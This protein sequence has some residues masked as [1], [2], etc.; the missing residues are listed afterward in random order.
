MARGLFNYF[1]LNYSFIHKLYQLVSI[2]LP[3]YNR[4]KLLPESIQS[5]LDQS[6]TDFE[7]I[8]T[9]DGSDDG[10][11]ELVMSIKD[12]RI[13]YFQFPH[14]GCTSRLKNFAIRQ[15]SGDFFAF[16]DSD[17]MWKPGKLEKQMNLFADNPTIGFSITDATT[18]R[19]DEILID[20]T[21]HLQNTVQCISIFTW[22]KQ[23][24]FIIYPATL[25]IRKS[26]LERTGYFDESMLSGD[27]AF[28]MRLAVHFDVGII[29]ESL[30]WRR[31]HDT[32]MSEQIP[33][34]NYG[35][36]IDTFQYLYREGKI[37]RK[38]LRQA[39]GNAYFKMG[40]IH[41]TSGSLREARHHYIIALKNNL[42][43]PRYVLS[44]LKSFRPG[45][46]PARP[47]TAKN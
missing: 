11:S 42:F 19:G 40:K 16:I 33:F 22:M 35:E 8:I 4:A 46:T 13:K 24:R 20:H 3:T 30:L 37:G 7:L 21:Y 34:E 2:I 39:L 41:E 36:Y 44:L 9:D 38:H 26:C 18:F 27:Y 43:Q 31:V 17:D 29:Y 47:G 28:N 1:F 15:S 32:N 25:I 12:S 6:Y 45:P 10:T 5:V 23:S 14:T